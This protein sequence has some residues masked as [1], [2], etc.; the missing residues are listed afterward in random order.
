MCSWKTIEAL[1]HLGGPAKVLLVS[2]KHYRAAP[3]LDE[4]LS[5]TQDLSDTLYSGLFTLL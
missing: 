1:R 2:S 3:E 5:S 4:G